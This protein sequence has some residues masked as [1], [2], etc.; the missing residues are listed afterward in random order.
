MSIVHADDQLPGTCLFEEGVNGLT[1][2]FEAALAQP[3]RDRQQVCKASK[4][5]G[6]SGT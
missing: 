3:G 2:E 5:D 6:R 1:E 4:W